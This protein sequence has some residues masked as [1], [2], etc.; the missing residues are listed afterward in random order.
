MTLTINIDGTTQ[1]CLENEAHLAGKSLEEYA[2]DVLRR[3]ASAPETGRKPNLGFAARWGI[4]ISDDFD[5]PLDDFK[6]Y[7]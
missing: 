7:M 1:Q 3:A 6:E 2:T 5:E 4:R